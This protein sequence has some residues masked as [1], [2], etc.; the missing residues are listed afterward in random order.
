METNLHRK[1]EEIDWQYRA[2]TNKR[3]VSEIK[4]Q[5]EREGEGGGR[6]TRATVHTLK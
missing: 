5:P 1:R 2:K 6:E 4:Q 3:I